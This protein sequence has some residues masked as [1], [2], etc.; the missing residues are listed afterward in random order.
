MVDERILIAFG[1]NIDP[2]KN[3]YRGLELLDQ[4][5]GIDTISTVWRSVALGDPDEGGGKEAGGDYLNGVVLSRAGAS[6]GDPLAL[7]QVLRSV[8]YRCGRRRGP[9]KYAP[10]TLDLD[11]VLMGSMVF[12]REGLVLPD[13]DLMAR[14]FLAFPCA[15]LA[16]DLI[17]PL[18]RLTLARMVQE[19]EKP[20]L[21]MRR[22][23]EAGRTLATLA[24][25][26]S[27]RPLRPGSFL[28]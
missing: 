14:P 10:R 9:K 13:P 22:D 26:K 1:S 28:R 3:I 25:E 5:I 2:L 16:P 27:W 12:D 23:E 7:R 19:L 4:E 17:H 21:A 6:V 8:E 20:E 11:I 15:E 24:V 18:E